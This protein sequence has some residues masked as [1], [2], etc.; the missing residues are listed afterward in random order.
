MLSNTVGDPVA[1]RPVVFAENDSALPLFVEPFPVVDLGE[2]A[3]RRFL[4]VD[5]G[6]GRPSR[7]V[8]WFTDIPT[9][10]FFR[11][12]YA[13]VNCFP[14]CERGR[15]FFHHGLFGQIRLVVRWRNQNPVKSRLVYSR[16]SLVL[17]ERQIIVDT[18]FHFPPW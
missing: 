14:Q 11:F 5:L 12:E 16:N 17:I 6:T 3:F 10:E 8:W 4:R 1:D 15:V 13:T 18:R 9:V 2:S 7:R